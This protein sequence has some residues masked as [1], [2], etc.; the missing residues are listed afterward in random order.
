MA[1]DLVVEPAPGTGTRAA[2][3]G[4]YLALMTA[5]CLGLIGH[6]GP[7]VVEG[8]FARNPAFLAM[9]GAVTAS[10]VETAASATGTSQG[11]ALLAAGTRAPALATQ[12][13]GPGPL[14]GALAAYARH[15]RAAVAGA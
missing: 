9:L 5:E 8:P 15:W 3:V 2:A 10:P 12:A 14:A 4:F 7:V 13:Q 6:R 1:V 11:A